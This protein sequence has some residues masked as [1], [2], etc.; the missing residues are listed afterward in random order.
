MVLVA[1][2]DFTSVKVRIVNPSKRKHARDIVLESIFDL[3]S[4][5]R[6]DWKSCHFFH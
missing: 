1:N 6:T 4:F 3:F 5:N 2:L